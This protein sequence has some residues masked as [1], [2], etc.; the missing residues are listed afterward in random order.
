MTEQIKKEIKFG[1]KEILATAS[2]FGIFISGIYLYA[3]WSVFNINFLQF[4]AISDLAKLAVF[5]L[6]TSSGGIVITA[7]YAV[8]RAKKTTPVKSEPSVAKSRFTLNVELFILLIMV[9]ATGLLFL[10]PKPY[11]WIGLT[12]LTI[13][14]TR[15]IVDFDWAKKYFPNHQLR[16]SLVFYIMLM[17]LSSYGWGRGDAY[18]LMTKPRATVDVA[19][20]KIT[21]SAPVAY[22]AHVG[23]YH[24]LYESATQQVVLIKDST[25]P[26]LYLKTEIS[27]LQP[28]FWKNLFSAK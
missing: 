19:R 14:I 23:E 25:V 5:P 26:M 9:V 4:A 12:L 2:A 16:Y 27:E 3:F 11:N 15:G 6:I 17:T 1:Y 28:P 10:A 13:P 8:F 7:S 21:L 22:M 24:F 20:S 18:I